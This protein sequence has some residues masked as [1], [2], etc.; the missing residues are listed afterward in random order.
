M[1]G[2]KQTIKLSIEGIGSVKIPISIGKL[3]P[4]LELSRSLNKTQ[5]NIKVDFRV[6]MTDDIKTSIKKALKV[7]LICKKDKSNKKVSP[8]CSEVISKLESKDWIYLMLLTHKLADF[9][10]FDDYYSPNFPA[11]DVVADS[12]FM[13]P[14]DYMPHYIN[15]YLRDCFDP[16]CMCKRRYH[17][18]YTKVVNAETWWKKLPEWEKIRFKNFYFNPRCEQIVDKDVKI[19]LISYFYEQFTLP[20]CNCLATMQETSF[21]TKWHSFNTTRPDL[22]RFIWNNIDREELLEIGR[23]IPSKRLNRMR[24][25]TFDEM[26]EY[27]EQYRPIDFTYDPIEYKLKREVTLAKQGKHYVT[28]ERYVTSIRYKKLSHKESVDITE[29]NLENYQMLKKRGRRM[30]YITKILD[31][32]CDDKVRKD[33]DDF[34]L[35]EKLLLVDPYDR[36][37]YVFLDG[38]IMIRITKPTGMRKSH[39]SIET[40]DSSSCL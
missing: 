38:G 39:G 25:S 6:N 15:M 28:S 20:K 29:K 17:D 10:F 26:N 22:A 32:E 37:T 5:N 13:M 7:Y 23:K 11:L 9:D 14:E 19:L 35:F 12:V 36:N 33:D 40:L 2:K 1:D 4:F 21:Y 24:K 3:I 18:N 34:K 27:I 8:D 16:E 31:E 30:E